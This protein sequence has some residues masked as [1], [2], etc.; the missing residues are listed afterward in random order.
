MGEGESGRSN[1]DCTH[2]LD[3]Q[4]HLDLGH[5]LGDPRLKG[6]DVDGLAH[7][8]GHGGRLGWFVAVAVYM[9]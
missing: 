8:S 2:L 3:V 1:G 9:G 6:A 4:G 5:I 7:A